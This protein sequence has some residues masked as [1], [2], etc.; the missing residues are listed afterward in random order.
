MMYIPCTFNLIL[1]KNIC[2][3]YKR[4][5]YKGIFL[6]D[7]DLFASFELVTSWRGGLSYTER[8]FNILK[9]K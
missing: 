9:I 5:S 8:K 6:H 7:S 1:N 2:I 4:V 3:I